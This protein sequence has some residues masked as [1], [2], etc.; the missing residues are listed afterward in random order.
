MCACVQKLRLVRKESFRQK[1]DLLVEKKVTGTFANTEIT[2][3][4]AMAHF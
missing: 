2:F 3:N 4:R 1:D